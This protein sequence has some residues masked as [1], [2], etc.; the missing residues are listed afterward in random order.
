MN[1]IEITE[2]PSDRQT[3]CKICMTPIKYGYICK[4]CEW[5]EKQESREDQ[6]E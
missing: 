2:A 6:D 5:M 3:F 4:A 1:N